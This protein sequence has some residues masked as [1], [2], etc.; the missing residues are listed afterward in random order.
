MTLDAS[1][2][3]LQLNPENTKAL[4]RKAN[5]FA[6]LNLIEEAI[7]TLRSAIN[8]DPEDQVIFYYLNSYSSESNRNIFTFEPRLWQDLIR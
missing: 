7:T 1:N 8:I 3:A 4:F 5:A 6:N 2:K